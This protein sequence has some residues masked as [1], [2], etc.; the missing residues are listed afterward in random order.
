MYDRV[1]SMPSATRDTPAASVQEPPTVYHT[2]GKRNKKKKKKK[3]YTGELTSKEAAKVAQDA[4]K[5]VHAFGDS[6]SQ[7]TSCTC[8]QPRP[9][10]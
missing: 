10:R 1:N 4:T 9:G 7:P 5:V 2:A 8:R 3:D 6:L